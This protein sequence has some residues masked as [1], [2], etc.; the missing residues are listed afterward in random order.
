MVESARFEKTSS[1]DCE[2]SN[3]NRGR[4][5]F[6]DDSSSYVSDFYVSDSYV[7]D[8]YV[9]FNPSCTYGWMA[10]SSFYI[11]YGGSSVSVSYRATNDAPPENHNEDMVVDAKTPQPLSVDEKAATAADSED[12]HSLDKESRRKQKRAQRQRANKASAAIAVVVADPRPSEETTGDQIVTCTWNLRDSVRQ[13]YSMARTSTFIVGTPANLTVTS[14]AA[15]TAVAQGASASLTVTP[16]AAVAV[17]VEVNV[18]CP[19]GVSASP[20][21]FTLL[22][23]ATTGQLITL[24]AAA[25][26]QLGAAECTLTSSGPGRMAVTTASPIALNVVDASMG[27]ASSSSTGKGPCVDAECGAFGAASLPG[28]AALAAMLLAAFAQRQ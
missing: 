19:V 12:L 3:V 28:L 11:P 26:A 22:A 24:A 21:T 6:R 7:S 25:D 8:F 23:G 27:G 17:D 10:P 18:A 20:A 9:S 14:T 15:P 4:W 1:R 5:P 13:R 2:R 16:S